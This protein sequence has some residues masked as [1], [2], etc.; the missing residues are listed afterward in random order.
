M[1]TITANSTPIPANANIINA[2]ASHVSPQSG[3][4]NSPQ[5]HVSHQRKEVAVIFV[6]DGTAR[7]QPH[8]QVIYEAY[9]D[10]I[11][12]QLRSPVI[13]EGEDG[14]TKTKITPVLKYGLT[15]FGDYEP[16]STNTVD[17]KYFT[18]DSIMFQDILKS[19]SCKKGGI[20]K[21]AVEEGLV[22]ALELFDE[23]RE[24]L[25]GKELIQHCILISNSIPHQIGARCN[26]LD[27]YSGMKLDDIARAMN[28]ANIKLSLISPVKD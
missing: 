12:K 10:P 28:Q 11:I 13:S 27:K 23:Y 20:I 16:L 22:A 5:V 1:S 8:F 7:M 24:E 17:R 2:P 14:Q 19:I 21:N 25:D 6:I 26:L 18:S 15:I 4:H 3:Q 9:I